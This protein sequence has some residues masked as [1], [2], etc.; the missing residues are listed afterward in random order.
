DISYYHV[1]LNGL[2]EELTD[3]QGRI[4]WHGEYSLWGK[5]KREQQNLRFQGQYFDRETGLHYNTFRYYAPDT[6]RF[7]Q[8]DPIG[9][10]G[11]LNLYA[12][13]LS[14]LDWVDPLG[15]TPCAVSTKKAN[16]MLDA[17]TDKVTV[18]SRSDAQQ[19]FMDRYVG[20]GYK[21]MTGESGPSTKNLMEYLTGNK[22]KAGTYH[23]DDV[24]D[25]ANVNRVMGHGPTN[26]DGALPHL[27]IHQLDGKVIHIFFPWGS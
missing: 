11:G 25:P 20:D 24:M 5:L 22:T 21:N 9:L 17:G 14:P 18:K 13:V 6:G 8:Q 10:A 16:S 7:T 19:L 15:L 12:Y 23:W 2:P 27:Q 4:V 3:S 26:P 1:A